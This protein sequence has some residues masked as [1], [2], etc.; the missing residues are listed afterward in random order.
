MLIL[1]WFDLKVSLLIKC[2]TMQHDR[3]ATVATENIESK[4]DIHL[5]T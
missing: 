4:I 2:T 3:K 1:N 5:W